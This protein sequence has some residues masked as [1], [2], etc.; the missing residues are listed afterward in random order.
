LTDG[1]TL[2]ALL[3]DEP[4]AHLDALGAVSDAP[5]SLVRT[6]LSPAHKRAA[7][8]VRPCTLWGACRARQG[9]GRVLTSGTLCAQLE[10]WMQEAGLRTWVDVLGNVHGRIE[11]PAG[12]PALLLGSHY[13]TVA[14]AGKYDGTLGIIVAVAALKALL[15]QA[16]PQGRH[17]CVRSHLRVRLGCQLRS[18]TVVAKRLK[19]VCRPPAT[20][21]CSAARP[22][23]R[24]CEGVAT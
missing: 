12:V 21:A 16:G 6:F 1:G 15:L 17:L 7:V 24:P 23:T 2:R 13:D 3:L 22:S 10:A 18:Q 14:D 20:R 4:V 19:R 11:G 8:L 9:R 5:D